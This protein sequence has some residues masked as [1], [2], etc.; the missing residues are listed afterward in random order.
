LD[1]PKKGTGLSLNREEVLF[2]PM[3]GN[4]KTNPN[5]E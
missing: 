4:K 2:N 1:D 3:G 5:F